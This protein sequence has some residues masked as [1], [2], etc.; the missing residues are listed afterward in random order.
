MNAEEVM[1][2]ARCD[3]LHLEPDEY[4]DALRAACGGGPVVILDD[5]T[6]ATLDTKRIDVDG[7]GR[8]THVKHV[9]AV[10]PVGES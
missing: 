3:Y 7:P 8:G 2:A 6:L 5:G 9:I 10:V 1:I 4:I